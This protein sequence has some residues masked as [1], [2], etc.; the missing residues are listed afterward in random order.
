[1]GD[2]K[3]GSVAATPERINHESWGAVAMNYVYMH[4]AFR[5]DLQRMIVACDNGSFV[6]SDLVQWRTILGRHS[7]LE[8]EIYVPALQSRLKDDEKLPEKLTDGKD[9]QSIDELVEK[10][11]ACSDSERSSALKEL[12]AELDSHQEK[13][14]TAVMPLLM[15]RFTTREL[16]AMNS[17]IANPKLDYCDKER[18]INVKQWW[19]GNV[20]E[21]E[22]K[23]VNLLYK[24]SGKN[25]RLPREGWKKLQGDIPALQKYSL[26]DFPSEELMPPTKE[27]CRRLSVD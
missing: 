20:T 1:M 9:H 4:N 26:D 5:N 19:F 23:Q 27:Y 7:R 14:E 24:M 2:L 3:A 6:E 25:P 12:V 8:D 17:C 21:S 16:N 15:E 13:E 18:K 22:A 11:L 10:A